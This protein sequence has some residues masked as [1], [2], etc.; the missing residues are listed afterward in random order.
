MASIDKILN[1]MR[2]NM[3]DWNIEHFETVARHYDVEIRKT[4]GN[5]VIFKHEQWLENLSV[6]AKRPIKPIYGP[7]IRKEVLKND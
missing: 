1:K 5:H 3:L 4:S 6:P 7:V 2:I